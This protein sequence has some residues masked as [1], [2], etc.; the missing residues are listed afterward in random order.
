[1]AGCCAWQCSTV[2][3]SGERV[4]KYRCRPG[5]AAGAHCMMAVCLPSALV[6]VRLDVN[7]CPCPVVHSLLP[8]DQESWQL[9]DQITG[10]AAPE[11]QNM[12]SSLD[13]RVAGVCNRAQ[14]GTAQNLHPLSSSRVFALLQTPFYLVVETSGSVPDHDYAKLDGFL[15]AAYSQNLIED[16]TIAQDSRQAA[17]IWQLRENISE[18]L[19]LAGGCCIV[20]ALRLHP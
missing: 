8:G 20:E 18:A 12:G 3:C 10:A 15:E 4:L 14:T 5:P 13:T 6:P 2:V 1:M 17:G 9:S 7:T 19:R 11:L 16:G